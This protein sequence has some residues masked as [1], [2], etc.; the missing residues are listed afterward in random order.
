MPIPVPSDV[1]SPPQPQ[2]D[3]GTIVHYRAYGSA[4]G[5]YPPAC[6]AAMVTAIPAADGTAQLAVFTPTGLHFNTCPYDQTGTA[7]GSWHWPETT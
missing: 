3:V 1:T 6:R 5:T 2:P 4:D 7:G